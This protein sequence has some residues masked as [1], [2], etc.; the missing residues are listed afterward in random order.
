MKKPQIY[1]NGTPIKRTAGTDSRIKEK[2]SAGRK[3]SKRVYF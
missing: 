3:G 2:G 1:I